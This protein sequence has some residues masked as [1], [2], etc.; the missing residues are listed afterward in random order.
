MEKEQGAN[1]CMNETPTCTESDAR[2]TQASPARSP[3]DHIKKLYAKRAIVG[4]ESEP[5]G[6]L[7]NVAEQLLELPGWT[8][9]DWVSHASQTLPYKIQQQ[10]AWLARFKTAA[11][12]T[13]AFR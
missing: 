9:P 7:S 3:S 13:E 10:L 5:G 6:L 11:L 12:S 8:Q 2:T 1:G 4:A